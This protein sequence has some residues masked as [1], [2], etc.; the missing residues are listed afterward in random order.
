[1]DMSVPP[2]NTT[3]RLG[4][5]SALRNH[6]SGVSLPELLI[7]IGAIAVLAGLCIP[8]IRNILPTASTEVAASNLRLINRAVLA[9]NQINTELVR[10]PD[11]GD[12][13]EIII[14]N[15]LKHRDTVNPVPGSPFLKAGVVLVTSSSDEDYRAS[16]NGRMFQ[17][18]TPGTEGAGLDL[19]RVAGGGEP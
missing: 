6:Q 17:L 3:T 2:L 15:A 19:L 11:E 16:W 4:F 10:E 14:F 7:V 12:A 9:Y 1:M 5:L 8:I 13:D 18:L